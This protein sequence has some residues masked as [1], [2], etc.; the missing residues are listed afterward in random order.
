MGTAERRWRGTHGD[1][2]GLGG[3]ATQ[4]VI[5]LWIQSMNVF[6]K[7]KTFFTRPP[8]TAEQKAARDKEKADERE[9]RKRNMRQSM[10]Q[11]GL[12]LD[13]DKS[14]DRTSATD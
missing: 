2:T 9:L 3:D 13:E 5:T 1:G 12:F 8:P 14:I 4:S 10:A 11:A 6:R 7:V